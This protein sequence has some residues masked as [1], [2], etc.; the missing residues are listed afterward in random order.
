MKYWLVASSN[1][2]AYIAAHDEDEAEM[3]AL[4]Y[5]KGLPPTRISELIPSGDGILPISYGRVPIIANPNLTE[6]IM[7]LTRFRDSLDYGTSQA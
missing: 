7:L 5:W 6:P 4:K 2:E 1:Y 3:V